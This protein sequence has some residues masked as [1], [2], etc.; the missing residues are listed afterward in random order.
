MN[1]IIRIATI[2]DREEGMNLYQ[3]LKG[4]PGCTW[5]D[6]YPT[7]YEVDQDIREQSL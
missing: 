6:E 5:D 7:F 1:L 2:S 3:S 4:T